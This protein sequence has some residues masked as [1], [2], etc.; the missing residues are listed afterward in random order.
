[1]GSVICSNCYSCEGKRVEMEWRDGSREKLKADDQ[2]AGPL[3]ESLIVAMKSELDAD[4][5]KCAKCGYQVRLE[6]HYA[7][8]LNDRVAAE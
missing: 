3:T 6:L 2:F 5:W 4:Y 1:M 8:E 7:Q